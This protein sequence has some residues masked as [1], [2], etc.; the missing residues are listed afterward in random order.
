MKIKGGI[1]AFPRGGRYVRA[2]PPGGSFLA[3][4]GTTALPALTR[5]IEE[6]FRGAGNSGEKRGLRRIGRAR[7]ARCG[8]KHC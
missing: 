7:G 3:A 2:S 8:V 4:L 5:N 1:R 6:I